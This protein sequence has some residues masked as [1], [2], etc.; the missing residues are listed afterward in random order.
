MKQQV[1]DDVLRSIG[2]AEELEPETEDR[3]RHDDYVMEM[4]QS[5]ER[6]RGRARMRAFQDRYP[7]PPNIS[8]RKIRSGGDLMVVEL[9][10]DYRGDIYYAALI[11]ELEQGKIRR[12]TR[13]YA[14]PFDPPTWRGHLV[15]RMDARRR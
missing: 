1:L 6:I 3:L 8:V 7:V 5:G 10:N 4:P 2:L 14:E 11:L 15:E 12:D 9:T 13:Y